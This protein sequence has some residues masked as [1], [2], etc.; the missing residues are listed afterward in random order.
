MIDW[1]LGS[2]DCWVSLNNK[3]PFPITIYRKKG[4]WKYDAHATALTDK[5]KIELEGFVK[6]QLSD[7]KH[8]W[9]L[10]MSTRLAWDMGATTT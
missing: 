6:N 9:R 7:L 2:V 1:E 4:E 3:K 5:E 8:L 10:N